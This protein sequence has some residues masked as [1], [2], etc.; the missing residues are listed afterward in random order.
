MTH[1]TVARSPHVRTAPFDEPELGEPVD[2]PH[3]G[4]VREVD[5]PLQHGDA[6]TVGVVGEGGQRRGLHHAQPGGRLDRGVDLRHHL[7]RDVAEDVRQVGVGRVHHRSLPDTGSDRSN[8]SG[9]QG[10]IPP[11]AS[12]GRRTWTVP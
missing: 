5:R 6:A 2:E 4:R 7:Q 12:G 8:L 11:T 9:R 3:R 1:R 10:I